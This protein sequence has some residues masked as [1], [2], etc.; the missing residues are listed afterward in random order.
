MARVAEANL[1]HLARPDQGECEGDRPLTIPF[2]DFPVLV[3]AANVE[4]LFDRFLLAGEPVVST[5]LLLSV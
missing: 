3:E 5:S 1:I 2:N 4:T